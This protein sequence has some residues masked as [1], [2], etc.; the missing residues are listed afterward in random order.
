MSGYVPEV[1]AQK[2]YMIHCEDCGILYRTMDSANPIESDAD[3]DQSTT[4]ATLA[5]A[6]R[7]I[8]AHQRY[9]KHYE[10]NG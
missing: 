1:T 6:K 3:G 7:S 8:A 5:D 2:V 9:H 4:T 10:S